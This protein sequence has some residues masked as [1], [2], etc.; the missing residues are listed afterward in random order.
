MFNKINFEMQKRQLSKACIIFYPTD[1]RQF[2]SIDGFDSST[3]H[4]KYGVPQGGICVHY[5]S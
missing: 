3:E 5:F 1:R 2:F 4:M